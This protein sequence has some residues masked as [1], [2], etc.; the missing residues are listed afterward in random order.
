MTKDSEKLHNLIIDNSN[1]HL[2]EGF[3][4]VNLLNRNNEY[5][6]C[7][8]SLNDDINDPAKM[9][10]FNLISPFNLMFMRI[11]EKIDFALKVRKPLIVYG[12]PNKPDI[13]NEDRMFS[14]RV[15]EYSYLCSLLFPMGFVRINVIKEENA[16]PQSFQMF[17]TVDYDPEKKFLVD[18]MEGIT[19][20]YDANCR[21]NV[22]TMMNI[23]H[24]QGYYLSM[25]SNPSKVV[26]LTG[27]GS[28][29]QI[30]PYEYFSNVFSMIENSDGSENI[31][32]II[33][34]VAFVRSHSPMDA[35]V[36]M[37]K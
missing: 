20:E 14:L 1:N 3:K 4:L 26:K 9:A 8:L 13:T 30:M 12:M 36:S 31:E 6:V 10:V 32:N 15:L 17:P 16:N 19:K 27:C 23:F 7:D 21:E 33:R 28:S 34:N 5:V 18:L 2:I 22:F 29:A 25:T 24:G 35:I 11:M 37:K